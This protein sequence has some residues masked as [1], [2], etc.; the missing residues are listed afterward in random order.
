MRSFISHIFLLGFLHFVSAQSFQGG[1]F[2]VRILH[3]PGFSSAYS[4]FVYQKQLY[5]VSDH[6]QNFAVVFRQ[7]DK[8]PFQDIFKTPL[9]DAIQVGK[10]ERLSV[11]L[12]SRYHDGSFCFTPTGCYV[13]RN[14]RDK[15]DKSKKRKLPLQ[16][17]FCEKAEDDKFVDAVKINFNSPDTFSFGHPFVVGDS[18]MYLVSD[19]PGGYGGTDIYFSRKVNGN[20]FLPINCGVNVNTDRNEL[21]PS[22]FNGQLFC[23]SDRF[24][25][26]GKLDIY[27]GRG[28]QNNFSMPELL[29]APINS[30]EDDFSFFVNE[31][32]KTGY[33]SSSRGVHDAIYFFE[34][35]APAEEIICNPM[36]LNNY[37]YTF[38]EESI[39]KGLDTSRIIFEW[40]FG[41]GKKSTQARVT[42]CFPGEG[43][44]LVQLNML[45]KSSGAVFFN[46]ASYE[47]QIRNFHQLY[48]DAPDTVVA[49]AATELNA[50]HSN[51]EFF[52]A[53]QYEWDFGDGKRD[54]FS[55]VSHVFEAPGKYRVQ[56]KV[57]GTQNKRQYSECVF[58]EL[59]VLPKNSANMVSSS[60]R[61]PLYFNPASSALTQNDFSGKD[62]ADSKKNILPK[63]IN[64]LPDGKQ[65]SRFYESSFGDSSFNYRLH[66]GGSDRPLNTNDVSFK[67]L[68]SISSIALSG[69]SHYFYGKYPSPQSSVSAINKLKA[70]GFS[71]FIF[72]FQGNVLDDNFNPFVLQRLLMN[73]FSSSEDS[74]RM[75]VYFTQG[76]ELLS[77]DESIAITQLTKK[78]NSSD[79]QFVLSGYADKQGGTDYNIELSKKRNET[80]FQLLLKNGVS[81]QQIQTINRGAV[82]AGLEQNEE[83]LQRDRRVEIYVFRKKNEGK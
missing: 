21:C 12:N 76:S 77:N 23:S 19:M 26:L 61:V 58:R 6:A 54:K 4:P 16:I 73:N 25:G 38:F 20:W 15:K 74:V 83:Q 78:Y 22:Y 3:I 66:I 59:M 18:L 49:G 53:Q 7:P 71:P 72:A 75:N 32:K 69:K 55:L 13:T 2:R 57:T 56:L 11:P 5:F 1:E 17:V 27:T 67:N 8:K 65:L 50:Y 80:V 42:H 44:F 14:Y 60:R 24:G 31:D 35:T 10:S 40:S 28:Q 33:F 48:I 29:G 63:M 47:L 81:A 62:S 70:M 68:D 43:D 41:D 34:H 64:P 82:N 36:K 46:Q 9:T 51:I 39:T 79:F 30:S 37:C 45:D 52:A